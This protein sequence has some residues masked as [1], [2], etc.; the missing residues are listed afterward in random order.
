MSRKPLTLLIPAA[1]VAALA[2]CN[3]T[4]G[5]AGNGVTVASHCQHTAPRTLALE[6]DGVSEL[7]LELGPDTLVLAG[8]PGASSGQLQGRACA[9][10]EAALQTLQL[11]QQRQ[12]NTLLVRSLRHKRNGLAIGN[13]SA[14]LDL[15]GQVPDTL[16]VTLR[17]GSGDVEVSKLASLRAAVGSG[18]VLAADIP[19]AVELTLGSGD[20]QVQRA[21]SLDVVNMGSGELQAEQ[22]AA[23]VRIGNIGSGDVQLDAVTGDVR[24][25]AI[26]S[27]DL[28]L[29]RIQGNV[30]VGA[31]GSGDIRA[32]QVSGD[33][34]VG[35]IGSGDVRHE[36][37]SGT[38]RLP[39]GK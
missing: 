6:L 23:G 39:H 25:Q 21:G 36:Q 3:V 9:S 10:S 28:A 5:P 32:R 20:V 24:V 38:L 17:L 12:G 31:I 37:V 7:V 15:R 30:V 22:I 1:L 4:V 35:R 29:T 26:G 27:G 33:L 2:G 34:E 19:G 8:Q 14:W 16:P 13:H 11:E 18:D